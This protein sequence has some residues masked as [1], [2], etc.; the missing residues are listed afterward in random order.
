M[1]S[2]AMMMA[3]ETPK[4]FPNTTVGLAMGLETMV[5]D[6][7]VLNLAA[8]DRGRPEAA[9]HAHDEDGR[10]AHIE[11]HLV[12]AVDF[13]GLGIAHGESCLWRC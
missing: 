5:R 1:M 7:L 8:D 2:V 10:H 9:D 4:Y 6:G 13:R 12:V 11:K 3:I